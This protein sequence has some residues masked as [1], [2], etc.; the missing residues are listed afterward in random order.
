MKRISVPQ[1]QIHPPEMGIKSDPMYFKTSDGRI[2]NVI[3]GD[4][5]NVMLQ[6]IILENKCKC[7]CSDEMDIFRESY[8]MESFD[9]N[10]FQWLVS[11]TCHLCGRAEHGYVDFGSFSWGSQD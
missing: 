5:G 6:E 10:K 4:D 8:R 9:E 2:F 3:P 1:I 7:R 11:N